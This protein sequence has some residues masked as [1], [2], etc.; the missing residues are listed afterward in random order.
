MELVT[1]L[2]MTALKPKVTCKVCVTKL[3]VLDPGFKSVHHTSPADG[4]LRAILPLQNPEGLV[5]GINTSK[6]DSNDR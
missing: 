1:G 5:L 2:A 3:V 4:K 6:E